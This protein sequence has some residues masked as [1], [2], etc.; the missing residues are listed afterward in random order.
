MLYNYAVIINLEIPECY[1]KTLNSAFAYKNIFS[2]SDRFNYKT[3]D[4]IFPS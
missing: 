2:P 4:A 3:G 1:C